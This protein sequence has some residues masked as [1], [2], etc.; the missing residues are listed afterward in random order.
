MAIAS[1]IASADLETAVYCERPT[2]QSE[3]HQ[4]RLFIIT[5][6]PTLVVFILRHGSASLSTEF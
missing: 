1:A 2:A 3:D 5:K 4:I 6:R